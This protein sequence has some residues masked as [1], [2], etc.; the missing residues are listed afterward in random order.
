MV[1]STKNILR[2]KKKKKKLEKTL[3]HDIARTNMSQFF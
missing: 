2:K 1:H 3:Y